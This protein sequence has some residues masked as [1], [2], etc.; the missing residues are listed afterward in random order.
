M[1]YGSPWLRFTP[2]SV[3]LPAGVCGCQML[4][5]GPGLLDVVV[6]D[7]HFCVLMNHV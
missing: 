6:G 2:Y 4:G 7:F 5:E 3:L 1:G